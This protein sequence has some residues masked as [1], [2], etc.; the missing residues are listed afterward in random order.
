MKNLILWTAGNLKL[1]ASKLGKSGENICKL[2][3]V[4]LKY[5]QHIFKIWLNYLNTLPHH[6]FKVLY[7]QL[8]SNK[9]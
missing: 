6:N 2:L 4:K 1:K 9:E 3:A 7:Q 8:L 5:Y